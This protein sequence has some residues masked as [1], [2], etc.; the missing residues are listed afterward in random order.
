MN[1]RPQSIHQTLE[2]RVQAALANLN[3]VCDSQAAAQSLGAAVG[4]AVSQA[5]PSS[6]GPSPCALFQGIDWCLQHAHKRKS[7]GT[8]KI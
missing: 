7:H 3:T 2:C 5:I 1:V 6:F 4:Q 8:A